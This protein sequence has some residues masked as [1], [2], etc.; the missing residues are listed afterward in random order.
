VTLLSLAA[1][2]QEPPTES[3]ASGEPLMSG[4]PE[5]MLPGPQAAPTLAKGTTWTYRANG[6]WDLE[7]GFSVVVASVAPGGYLFAATKKDDIGSIIVWDRPW[8]GQRDLDLNPILL[9]GSPGRQYYEFPLEDGKSWSLSPN[10]L[11]VT[12][13]RAVIA[14][15]HGKEAGFIIKG[16]NDDQRYEYDYAPS[17]GFFTRFVWQVGDEIR[18]NAVLTAT[19]M[20]AEWVWFERTTESLYVYWSPDPDTMPKGTLTVPEGT[21]VVSVIGY[22][23]VGARGEVVPPA[24]PQ[25]A[26]S[27][28]GKGCCS[29]A[30]SWI[31]EVL[32]ATPGDWQFVV[33]GTHEAYAGLEA[34][35]AKWIT[36]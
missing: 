4:E 31:H 1:C 14:T 33:A 9:D 36:S 5:P 32:P 11:T 16:A 20:S 27:F 13:A 18:Y 23:D 24:E 6:T 25:R 3:P 8:F 21:D 29:Q 19:S 35:A 22:G 2:V 10:G 34:A 28:E 26:W 15:P 12:A 17:L 30:D 7:T